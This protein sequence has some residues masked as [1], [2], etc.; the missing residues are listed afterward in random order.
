MK[1]LIA[2][3]LCACLLLAGCGIPDP[4]RPAPSRPDAP[5]AVSVPEQTASSHP[6]APSAPAEQ[7]GIEAE[8][9]PEESLSMPANSSPRAILFPT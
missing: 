4:P 1:R 9:P 6:E 5:A 7:P 8:P 2:M 3:L